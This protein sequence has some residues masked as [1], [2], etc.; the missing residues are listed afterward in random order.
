MKMNIPNF[1]SVLRIACIPLFIILL[2]YDYHLAAFTVFVFAAITDICDGFFARLLNQKTVLGAYLD[3]IAD[4]LLLVSSFVTFVL[5]GLI[6]LW[7]AVLVVSR[8]V[9]ISTGIL[10]LRLSAYQ[11]EVKPSNL[12]KCT[13]FLQIVTI[14]ITL[15]LHILGKSSAIIV[16]LYWITGILTIGS[17]IH[18]ISRGM[19]LTIPNN[20]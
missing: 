9:L 20:N 1:F 17:G 16:P 2:S 3:P 8:D 7:L 18:Y 19:K 6:P 4:K 10:I 12:S 5:M 13:T 14:G 11:I 15:L